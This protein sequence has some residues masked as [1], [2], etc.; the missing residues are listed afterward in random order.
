MSENGLMTV[1]TKKASLLF[2]SKMLDLTHKNSKPYSRIAVLDHQCSTTFWI[3][4]CKKFL[5]F[6]KVAWKWW[7]TLR[8]VLFFF[9]K[10]HL[11]WLWSI[12]KKGIKTVSRLRQF[13]IIMPSKTVERIIIHSDEM[14]KPHAPWGSLK[15]TINMVLQF[16]LLRYSNIL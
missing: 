1:W 2:C 3:L 5:D 12:K 15:C 10:L 6:I 9:S 4:H 16:L 11:E 7:I 14:F 8:S 13:Q